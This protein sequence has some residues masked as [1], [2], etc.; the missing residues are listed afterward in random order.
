MRV[1]VGL[2]LYAYRPTSPSTR[3]RMPL[4]LSVAATAEVIPR[5][6]NSDPV[7]VSVIELSTATIQLSPGVGLAAPVYQSTAEAE[8][9]TPRQPRSRV[10]RATAQRFEAEVQN[11]GAPGVGGAHPRDAASYFSVTCWNSRIGE[12]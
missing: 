5:S 9:G 6:A 12:N 11:A 7:D 1:P 4:S 3:A 8:P 2:E 10:T